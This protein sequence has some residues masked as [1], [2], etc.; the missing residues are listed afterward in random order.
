LVV[1]EG[2]RSV[3][4]TWEAMETELTDMKWAGWTV[5]MKK[6]SVSAVREM[7]ANHRQP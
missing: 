1:K 7:E 2:W 6:G 5:G 3:Y 4:G